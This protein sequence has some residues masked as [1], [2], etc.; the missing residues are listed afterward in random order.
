MLLEGTQ[1]KIVEK[2]QSN[3]KKVKYDQDKAYH[4]DTEE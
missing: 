3:G 2:G 1:W 4:M